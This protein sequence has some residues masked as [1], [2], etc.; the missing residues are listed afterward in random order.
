MPMPPF[1][2]MSAVR[3]I[4]VVFG[5]VYL[6]HLGPAGAPWWMFGAAALACFF[7]P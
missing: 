2:Y 3:L 6:Y 4:G 5:S 7:L 1:T